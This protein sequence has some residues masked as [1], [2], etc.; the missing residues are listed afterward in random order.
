MRGMQAPSARRFMRQKC[1]K[2]KKEKE[3][4]KMADYVKMW[5]ELGM[6]LASHDT[7]C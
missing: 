5:E 3:E 2:I 4:T 1:R 6:D 7:L